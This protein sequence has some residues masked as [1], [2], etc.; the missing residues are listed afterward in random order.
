MTQARSRQGAPWRALFLSGAALFWALSANAQTE[1]EWSP[2]TRV[3]PL[4]LAPLPESPS[5]WSAKSTPLAEPAAGSSGLNKTTSSAT[6]NRTLPSTSAL[7]LQ[8]PLSSKTEVSGA[9]KAERV[10]P[11][12]TVPPYQEP[13]APGPKVTMESENAKIRSLQKNS[14]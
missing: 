11:R 2:P 1:L 3:V 13:T 4:R 5:E 14:W 6:A 10:G 7:I 12:P 8:K 9:W